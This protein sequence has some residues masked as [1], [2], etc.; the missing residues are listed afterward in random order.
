MSIASS[1]LVTHIA[2]S[3]ALSYRMI[4]CVFQSVNILTCCF[5]SSKVDSLLS[6]R[7]VADSHQS[8]NVVVCT[9]ER[10]LW[11]HWEGSGRVLWVG[12]CL[13]GCHLVQ[14]C[15]YGMVG[16]GARKTAVVKEN[17]K[18][19]VAA[20]PVISDLLLIFCS[21][22]SQSQLSPDIKYYLVIQ[23]NKKAVKD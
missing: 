18:L 21:L 22:T 9:H 12:Q 11:N 17:S 6:T 3:T 1:K 16:G 23:N 7:F 2:R 19:I 8:L 15:V 10:R 20:G 5:V 4:Q 14:N 13:G